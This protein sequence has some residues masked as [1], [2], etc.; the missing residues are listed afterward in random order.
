MAEGPGPG[1][2]ELKCSFP[3]A[4][5][6]HQGLDQQGQPMQ[7]QGASPG[8]AG[9][10][11]REAVQQGRHVAGG[12]AELEPADV[13]EVGTR[14][15]NQVAAA[16]VRDEALGQS[17]PQ[18]LPH[19]LQIAATLQTCPGAIA[20]SQLAALHRQAIGLQH[21]PPHGKARTRDPGSA[22]RWRHRGDGER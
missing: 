10:L 2:A 8:H 22:K 15:R 6:P 17:Q 3:A 7:R 21:R 16:Q 12:G 20:G 18:G 4:G 1:H 5:Q 9:C 19:D 13:S 14:G 11:V